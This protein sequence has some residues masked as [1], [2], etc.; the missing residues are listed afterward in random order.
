MAVAIFFALMLGLLV[1]IIWDRR[2]PVA[3]LSREVMKEGWPRSPV[4][5][6]PV[7]AGFSVLSAAL[8]FSDWVSPSHPPFTGRL[9]FAHAVLYDSFGPRGPAYFL[10]ALAMGLAVVAAAQWR[11][12]AFSRRGA[13]AVKR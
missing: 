9:S 12:A 11:S 3:P 10:A 4:S 7:F 8:G 2:R 13:R 6:W 5:S 1:F